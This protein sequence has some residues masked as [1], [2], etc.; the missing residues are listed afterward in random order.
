MY[1]R[2]AKGFDF[3]TVVAA[4]WTKP[5]T[6]RT[7]IIYDR[8]GAIEI[9]VSLS[10]Y[11]L[12][13]TYVLFLCQKPRVNLCRDGIKP[14]PYFIIIHSCYFSSVN[15]IF[16]RLDMFSLKWTVV[17]FY[18]ENQILFFFAYHCHVSP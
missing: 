8:Y 9:L 11:L 13:N 6:V 18:T 3:N 2:I 12:H 4:V 15:I 16:I 7:L 17:S 14:M 1:S 10:R 5:N